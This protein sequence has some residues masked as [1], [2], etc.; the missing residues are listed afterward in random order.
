MKEELLSGCRMCCYAGQAARP[1]WTRGIGTLIALVYG[2]FVGSLQQ[3]WHQQAVQSAFTASH[4]LGALRSISAAEDPSVSVFSAHH[5]SRLLVLVQA[6]AH[7]PCAALRADVA[8]AGPLRI[9]PAAAAAAVA[10]H[11]EADAAHDV[12]DL[13]EEDWLQPS[14][15]EGMQRQ[16]HASDGHHA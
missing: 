12:V 15:V 11:A 9:G 4:E 13:E 10:A 5:T 16:V 7:M 8:P 1:A 6:R 14:P 2:T 3:N